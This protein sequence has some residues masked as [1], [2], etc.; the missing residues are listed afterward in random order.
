MLGAL[1][2]SEFGPRIGHR[3][4]I[5]RRGSRPIRFDT[6]KAPNARGFFIGDYEGLAD[7]GLGSFCVQPNRG[8]TER[9]GR[10]SATVNP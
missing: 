1:S 2:C 6:A 8:N 9:H 7:N 10:F 4:S 5:R 3:D